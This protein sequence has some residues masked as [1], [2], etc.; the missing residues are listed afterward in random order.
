MLVY[1]F[2]VEF[3]VFPRQQVDRHEVDAV[4]LLLQ[5]QVVAQGF[6]AVE[7][8]QSRL[9]GDEEGDGTSLQ[10]FHIA[11]QQVVAHQVEV[12]DASLVQVF[13]DD[14]RFRVESDAVVQG[15]VGLE[16]I[17]Q[18]LGVFR[19]AFGMQV[20]FP[21][22]AGGVMAF[23]VFAEPDFAPLLLVGANHSFVYLAE[24]DYFSRILAGQQHQHA[25]GKKS[26]L[27]GVLTEERKGR[28]FLDIRVYIYIRYMELVQLLDEGARILGSRRCQ[29]YP[30]RLFLYNLLRSLFERVIVIR[31]VVGNVGL[32]VEVRVGKGGFADACFDVGPVFAASC[33]GSRQA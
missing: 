12:G 5:N 30:V 15:G 7:S 1:R 3:D 28:L 6:D 14:V 26:A 31:V 32:D 8:L 24:D 10:A 2:V 13:A 22:V 17:V 16:E 9:L 33:W 27:V 20:Q 29:Q 19:V 11:L 23:H 18:H 25:C 4:D 21:D